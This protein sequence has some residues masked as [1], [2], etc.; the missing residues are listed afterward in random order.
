MRDRLIVLSIVAV[1]LAGA[2]CSAPVVSIEHALPAAVPIEGMDNFPFA[3]IAVFGD[4]DADLGPYATEQMR[5][6]LALLDLLNEPAQT[7]VGPEVGGTIIVTVEETTGQ[8]QVRH[9]RPGDDEMREE[10]VE[11]LV[12]RV[13]VAAAFTLTADDG[14][15]PVVIEI[16]RSYDSRGDPR[17]WGELGLQRPDDPSNIVPTEQVTRH[18]VVQCIDSFVEMIRP[19]SIQ[20]DVPMRYAGPAAALDAAK[21]GR[22][23]D[24]LA[25]FEA[26]LSDRPKDANLLFNAGVAAEAADNLP[27]AALHYMHAVEASDGDDADAATAYLRVV[28]VVERRQRP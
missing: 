6:Q 13:D 18:L 10:T 11:S 26:A 19:L 28:S 4:A 5:R 14:D 27:A 2:G 21:E 25:A 24:A 1:A 7:R 17:T 22:F 20:V 16:N 23:A 3:A 8:R 9:W 12:R 15:E